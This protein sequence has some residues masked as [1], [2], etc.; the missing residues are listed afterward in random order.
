MA[1]IR[2]VFT[3][4]WNPL[5]SPCKDEYDSFIGTIYRL[6]SNGATD[7]EIEKELLRIERDLHLGTSSFTI[8]QT[9]A[10]LRAIKL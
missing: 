6:L 9:V 3:E 4:V 7:E 1:D 8:R 2:R 5:R 10:A